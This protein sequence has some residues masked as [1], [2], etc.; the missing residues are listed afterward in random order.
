MLTADEL[1]EFPPL[2]R[3][4]VEHRRLL[5]D[6][7]ETV[8]FDPDERIFEEGQAATACWLIRTGRVTLDSGQP[9]GPRYVVQTLGPGDVLGW[10]WLVPP[11]RWQLGATAVE[12]VTAVRLD[13]AA[14]RAAAD[15]DP[16]FGYPLLLGL[17]AALLPR[18][19]GTR[20]RLLDLYGN[21]R[22]R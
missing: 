2:A 22:D 9:A 19:H 10:S 3:L 1:L 13:A 6:I 12:R 20:A 7:A 15:S 14:V 18:L 4:G 21:P 5:A 16:A 11:Y 17:V 8:T